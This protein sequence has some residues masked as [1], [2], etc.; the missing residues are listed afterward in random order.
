[1]MSASCAHGRPSDPEPAAA[2]ESLSLL[3]LPQDVLLSVL[4]QSALGSR[5]LARLERASRVL[6]AMLTDDGAW[7]RVYLRERKPPALAQPD[8]WKAELRARDEWSRNWRESGFLET[9]ESCPDEMSMTNLNG[10]AGLRNCI[11]MGTAAVVPSRKKLRKLAQMMLPGALGGGPAAGAI[12]IVDPRRV[13]AG[14]YGTIAAA[15]AAARPQDTVV[16]TS[17]TY[18]ERLD[19]DKSI[20]VVG[21][22]PLGSV[23]IVC[24]DEPC[25]SISSGRVACRVA[26][27]CLEQRASA[28]G[29]TMSEAV[30][31]EG[32]GALVLEECTVASAC[33][34]CVVIKGPDSCGY[35]L[36]NEV[37][38]ARGVGVLVCD[39]ARGLVEDNDI[40]ENAR[41][42]VAIL[43]GANPIV[44][45]NKIHNGRDSG[46]LV[47]ERGRG[48]VD[49]NDIYEN[50]RAGV[51]ILREGAPYVTRNRIFNGR[52]SG[53]LVCEQGKGSVVD[54]EIYSNH[55]AGVAIGHGGASTVKGN[56]I[57]D[58]SGGS[59]LCLSTHSRGLIC[60]NV[61]DQD[62]GATLQ[63]PGSLLPEVQ[64]QN[65]IRFIGQVQLSC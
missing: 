15:I 16:V 8:S 26:K 51:A 55:M 43:S 22:G 60:A 19:I 21:A 9:S 17:G 62:V 35:I 49:A 13:H 30:R 64:E 6:R 31:V 25:L 57:R 27:L 2:P 38:H 61:I 11:G 48:R 65:L 33:G 56:T 28:E 3:N 32:G 47:S 46:V 42:G 24:T 23:T 12:H 20:D 10:S 14:C 5:E 58:G 63:V 53:V 45:A 18:Q 34:H 39:H 29:G 54:N 1:M 40:Y 41:A 4:A 52:D 44:R 36:H 50:L 37:R 59:L 7:Q